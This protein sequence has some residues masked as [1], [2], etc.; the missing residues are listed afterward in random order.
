MPINGKSV[1]GKLGGSR[2]REVV[3]AGAP[4]CQAAGLGDH[5]RPSTPALRRG[6]VRKPL[7]ALK[8]ALP[9][10]FLATVPLGLALGGG[11]A[12]LTVAAT[13]AGLVLFDWALGFE[14][15]APQVGE[16]AAGRALPALYAAAQIAV[17][18]AIAWRIAQPRTTA[19]EALGATLSV[20]VAA[21][22]FGMLAAHELAHR[23]GTAERA[24]GLGLLALFGYMHFAIAHI[25]GHHVRAATPADPTSARRGED[26]YRF[27]GRSV[28]GQVREAWDFETKRLRRRGRSRLGPANRLLRYAAVEL[29]V[30]AGF[31]ALGL[32][33]FAFWLGQALLAIVLLELFNY[34]AHYG[35][36]RRIGPDGRLERLGP[37]HSW[38]VSRRMNN[39]ALFNMGRHSDHHRRPARAYPALEK[40]EGAP[41]LPAGYAGA[42]L[43]AL[44]PPLW[45]RVMDPRLDA[46][47]Q[48]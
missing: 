46:L 22:V 19:V 1:R 7:R 11:W 30:V 34:I 35:L 15:P 38:N 29:A 16:T 39:A 37:R 2:D 14:P 3:G 41:E 8:F 18:V 40:V 13:P 27:V 9:F 12:F 4:H 28:V 17:T 5:G 43:M 36:A 20:G 48:A 47:A 10:L 32:Q 25:H 31:A 23:R 24:V 21:G 26:A 33:A 44:V 45:R 42:I 6:A